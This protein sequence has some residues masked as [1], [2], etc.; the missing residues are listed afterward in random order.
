[1]RVIKET[2]NQQNTNSRTAV[3]VEQ[4]VPAEQAS[5]ASGDQSKRS[6][7]RREELTN[8]EVGSKTT[9]TVSEGY[10]IDQLTVAVVINR[11]R[12]LA[13]LGEGAGPEAV[14]KQ[15]KEVERLI[16]SAAGI[17]AKRGDRITVAAVEFLQGE[18]AARAGRLARHRRSSCS[19]KWAASS[20]PW[21]SSA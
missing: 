10:K 15:L 14:D 7:E 20:T 5:T 21:P 1:M 18:P 16:E 13:S 6:N 19:A 17:D 12:L 4:N 11:K 8:Y 9:S 2:G 3:G